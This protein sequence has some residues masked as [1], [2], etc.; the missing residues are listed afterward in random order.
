[1]RSAALRFGVPSND[2]VQNI[3]S[4]SRCILEAIE[5]TLA[6]NNEDALDAIG[7]ALSAVLAELFLISDR[8]TSAMTGQTLYRLVESY[9]TFNKRR[10]VSVFHIPFEFRDR[11]SSVRY[12]VAGHPSLYLGNSIY[13]CWIEC[14][15]PSDLSK[16][17]AARF[18]LDFAHLRVLDLSVSTALL[19]SI[20]ELS[21]H[22]PMP[23]IKFAP[24]GITNSPFGKNWIEY[25]ECSL[26]V[27]P[28]LAACSITAPPTKDAASK[29]EYIIPQLVMKWVQRSHDVGAIRFFSTKEQSIRSTQDISIN[30]ALPAK[31]TKQASGHDAFLKQVARCTRPV[32]I[33]EF[34]SRK[35]HPP[36]ESDAYHIAKGNWRRMTL[37][38]KHGGGPYCGTW[39]CN[40][41][42]ELDRHQTG[43]IETTT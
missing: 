38:D 4:L 31:I 12:S 39:Y 17:Y 32:S 30:Y 23:G 10:R 33:G 6:G 15:E 43:Q 2:H 5:L 26:T 18:D 21:A 3:D 25:L 40:L 19:R 34:L 27:W 16:W 35:W 28:L 36:R 1:M 41:E 37:G 7:K 14:H 22:P 11:A 42:Y 29:P 13:L 8:N 24:G 20:L 9:P